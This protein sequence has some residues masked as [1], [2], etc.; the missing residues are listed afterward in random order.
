[1]FLLIKS[2]LAYVKGT[3]E[4]SYSIVLENEW[5][6]S[7]WL[8]LNKKSTNLSCHDILIFRITSLVYSRSDNNWYGKLQKKNV[9]R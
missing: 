8:S 1:M 6:R 7:L 4:L 5:H 9:Q 3:M 2:T